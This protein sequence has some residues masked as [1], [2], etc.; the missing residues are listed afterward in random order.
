MLLSSAFLF[1]HTF[2]LPKTLMHSTWKPVHAVTLTVPLPVSS[3]LSHLFPIPR[4][5]IL[6]HPT[7]RQRKACA[8]WTAAQSC[9]WRPNHCGQPD[10]H[11]PRWPVMPT[12]QSPTWTNFEWAPVPQ[13]WLWLP[14][15]M[16]TQLKLDL[17]PWCQL[18]DS[19]SP[20]RSWHPPLFWICQVQLRVFSLLQYFDL[21]SQSREWSRVVVELEKFWCWKASLCWCWKKQSHEK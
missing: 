12:S 15:L 9:S 2:T 1:S 18:W 11:P 14:Q 16:Q 8:P 10:F 3:S 17:S 21:F 4:A 13:V 6:P 20:S 19:G 5:C 7:Q